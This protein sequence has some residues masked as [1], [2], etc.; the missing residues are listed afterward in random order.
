MCE[1]VCEGVRG[2]EG[3]RLA[4]TRRVENHVVGN[5]EELRP[6]IGRERV[7]GGQGVGGYVADDC[8]V[9][10]ERDVVRGVF[11]NE[12]TSGWVGE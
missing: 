10:R 9:E 7:V 6:L 3:V 5:I 4:P 11:L 12:S 2:C 1:C 8:S